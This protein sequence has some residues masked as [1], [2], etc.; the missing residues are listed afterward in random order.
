MA[1]NKR[2]LTE[3]SWIDIPLGYTTK[4]RALVTLEKGA[5]GDSVFKEAFAAWDK[6]PAATATGQQ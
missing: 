4:R 5:I 6:A 2:L 1:T 3:S